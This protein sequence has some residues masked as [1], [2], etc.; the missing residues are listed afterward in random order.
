MTTLTLKKGDIFSFKEKFEKPLRQFKKLYNNPNKEQ[1]KEN[2][3]YKRA[4]NDDDNKIYFKIDNLSKEIEKEREEIQKK[5]A[6]FIAK[7]EYLTE[8]H[9]KL[10]EDYR[11][12]MDDKNEK[13]K[14][15]AEAIKVHEE[16]DKIGEDANKI[17]E[18]APKLEEENKKILEKEK[19][20]RKLNRVIE[21]RDLIQK[22]INFQKFIDYEFVYDGVNEYIDVLINVKLND[23]DCKDENCVF[24][25]PKSIL[26]SDIFE[27]IQS[28][29][30]QSQPATENETETKPDAESDA[31]PVTETK[32]DA[33]SDANAVT[34]TESDTKLEIQPDVNT[35]PQGGKRTKRRIK[36]YKRKPKKNRKSN[37]KRNKK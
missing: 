29:E 14:N 6:I 12:L 23:D 3:E 10:K 21:E 9:K 18:E 27:L 7:T 11:L 17:K 34:D 28:D 4:K 16:A 22:I 13:T 8:R 19:E 20:L 33:E 15:K 2:E 5:F 37:K 1:Y 36:S 30:T 32:P 25:L 35:K 26:R 24:F 31:N